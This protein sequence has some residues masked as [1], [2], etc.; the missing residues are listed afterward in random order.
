MA[1]KQLFGI[2]SPILGEKQDFPTILL[3]NTI[4]VENS[5]IVRKYGEVRRR[6]MREPDMLDSSDDKSQIPDK[7]PIIHYHRFVKR[8]TGAEYKLAFTKAHIYLWNTTTK[9]W[10]VK[11]TC[12]SDCTEWDTETYNDMVIATN[13][14]DMVLKWDTTGYFIPL[15]NTTAINITAATKAST[16]QVTAG[17]HGLTTGDRVFIKDVV[18]MTQI[19]NLQFVVTV[20][21]ADKFTL[22]D[23]D[24]SAY[25]TYTSGG[26]VVEFEGIEYAADTYLTKARYVT[27][28][29]NYLILGYT[30]EDGVSYP[31]RERWNDIGD[32][33][34]WDSEDAGS[35]ET[36]GNE[37]IFGFKIYAGQL[38][39]FKKKLRIRQ[40]LVSTSD[41][42][43]WSVIPGNIGGISNHS[44]VEDPDGRVYWL[45]ND[46]TIRE[47]EE[48]EIS[49]AIKPIMELIEASATNLVY[50]A[51]I[52]ETGEIWWSIP[53]Q[54]SLNNKVI[55][56]KNG[57]WGELNLEVPAFGD[58]YEAE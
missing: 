23:I 37:V 3:D 6:Q 33:T 28:F 9:A 8:T 41:V 55:T 54:N 45:A 12:Q 18:G 52:A 1:K 35:K 47:M 17:T 31:Q 42:W 7:N 4:Q 21:D 27:T 44:I 46:L 56:Y 50:G 20:V 36:E 2:F 13:Y 57:S 32:E 10:D 19:N 16:C 22:D 15:Q 40:W 30:F 38:I 24:S 26:T 34:D 25:T 51:Y 29:E 11:F 53:Y 43:N 14:V 58:Y 39:I 5:N 49:Q 48:G